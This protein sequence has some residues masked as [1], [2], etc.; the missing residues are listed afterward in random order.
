M[1]DISMKRKKSNCPSKSTFLEVIIFCGGD[2]KRLANY[3]MSF[4]KII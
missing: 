2:F 4:V 1:K 3:K